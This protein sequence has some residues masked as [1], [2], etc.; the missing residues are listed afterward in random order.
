MSRTRYE[1]T[2]GRQIAGSI[3]LLAGL[4][5][6]IW[7]VVQYRL[8]AGID[9]D[10]FGPAFERLAEAQAQRGLAAFNTTDLRVPTELII[11]GGPPRDGIPSLV[12]P[13]A[14][15]VDAAGGFDVQQRVVLVR[16][17]G[18]TRAY[19]INVLMWHE[20]VNDTLGDV[21]IAVVYCPLCDSVSVVDRRVDDRV[22]EFG[23]SGL[24]MHSN[25]LMYD[26]SHDALW[27][28]LGFEAISGPHAGRGLTHLPW[29]ITTLDAVRRD[30]PD[31]T[32]VTTRTGYRRDYADT[33]YGDYFTTDTLYFPVPGPDRRLALKEPVVGV[34]GNGVAKAYPVVA[35]RAAG[36]EVRDVVGGEAVHI[37][38]TPH[39]DAVTV[40][41]VPADMRVAHTYWFAWAAFHP[42]TG[43]WGE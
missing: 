3:I 2:P 11:P 14:V 15:G 7:S 33:P 23:V 28:Q 27:S 42:E 32:I 34:V 8:T 17:A 10:E 26:R 38:V 35:L 13:P 39:S 4:T 12:R 6:V 41:E 21:P 16:Q 18:A 5:F 31:A 19:P 25:V 20:I 9:P 1:W 22:L 24:V 30:H 29:S 37:S 40:H 36:G 43:V